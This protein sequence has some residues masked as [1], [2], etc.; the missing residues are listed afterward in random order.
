MITTGDDPFTLSPT[1][2]SR[3]RHT[4]CKQSVIFDDDE[5]VLDRNGDDEYIDHNAENEVIVGEMSVNAKMNLISQMRS[6]WTIATGHTA[7]LMRPCLDS[8]VPN[9]R[10]KWICL[11]CTSHKKRIY[12]G[13]AGFKEHNATYHCPMGDNEDTLRG[14]P[15]KKCIAD[16]SKGSRAHSNAMQCWV[17]EGNIKCMITLKYNEERDRNEFFCHYCD[18]EHGRLFQSPYAIKEHSRSQGHRDNVAAYNQKKRSQMSKSTVDPRKR[19]RPSGGGGGGEEQE[20]GE[21]VAIPHKVLQQRV[22]SVLDK[23]DANGVI[24]HV[25]RVDANGLDELD[26][27][28]EQEMMAHMERNKDFIKAID[29]RIAK[30]E[31]RCTIALA[32]K[33]IKYHEVP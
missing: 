26:R 29:E 2:S 17:N 12:S 19:P 10:A 30:A 6:E 28:V 1:L 24:T 23:D 5:A 3:N 15:K 11:K 27:I 33:R 9:E 14:T 16:I 7:S 4:H 21:I 8:H 31:K 22:Q 32:K 20:A 25:G 18:K 13:I